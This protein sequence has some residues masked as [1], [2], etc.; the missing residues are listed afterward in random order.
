MKG[1]PIPCSTG[2]DIGRIDV[3]K[4]VSIRPLVLMFQ[5]QSYQKNHR[6]VSEC[7]KTLVG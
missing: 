3:H 6:L 7:F 1:V 2:R 4:Q 5:A